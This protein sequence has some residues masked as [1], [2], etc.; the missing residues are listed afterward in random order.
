MPGRPQFTL[1]MHDFQPNAL[2]S[3]QDFKFTPPAG[4]KR[5]D[6]APPQKTER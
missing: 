4:A 6:F 5:V 2:A 1:E 3:A